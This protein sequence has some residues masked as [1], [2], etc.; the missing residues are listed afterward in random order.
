MNSVILIKDS[1]MMLTDLLLLGDA[2]LKKNSNPENFR[3][4]WSWEGFKIIQ[5]IDAM[6]VDNYAKHRN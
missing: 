1:I 6:D 4:L 5:E 2:K 3:Q